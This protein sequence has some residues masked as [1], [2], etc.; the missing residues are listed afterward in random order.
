[1]GNLIF[2]IPILCIALFT[3]LTLKPNEFGKPIYSKYVGFTTRK[4]IYEYKSGKR[5]ARMVRVPYGTAF[6]IPT[7]ISSNDYKLFNEILNDNISENSKISLAI[8]YKV[9]GDGDTR[10]IGSKFIHLIDTESW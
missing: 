1:M 7:S 8:D 4:I 9:C 3:I 2:L 5:V 6:P 10:L